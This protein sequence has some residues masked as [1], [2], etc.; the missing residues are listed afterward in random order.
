MQPKSF[1]HLFFQRR[2]N[3]P[4]IDN[5]PGK[6]PDIEPVSLNL[7]KQSVLKHANIFNHLSDRENKSVER[8]IPSSPLCNVPRHAM[9]HSLSSPVQ[10]ICCSRR[11]CFQENRIVQKRQVVLDVKTKTRVRRQ[12]KTVLKS[13]IG[14]GLPP[15]RTY[16]RKLSVRE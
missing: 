16:P 10:N 6:H 2:P 12:L 14:A 8:R 7:D 1:D 9:I 4:Y 5:R 15:K 3:G 11:L 13:K